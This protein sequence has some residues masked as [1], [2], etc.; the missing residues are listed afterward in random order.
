[1]ISTLGWSAFGILML[2]G[3]DATSGDGLARH[4]GFGP[5]QIYKLHNG[6]SELQ[7]ADLDG[8]GRNDIALWNRWKNRIELFYQ[9]GA[10]ESAS[11]PAEDLERNEIPSRGT[12]RRESIPVPHRVSTLRVGEFTG[13][14]RLDLIYFGEPRELVILP[15]R[16]EGG[17]GPAITT[18]APDGDPRS[19]G[20]AIGDFNGDGRDDAVLRG[21]G[22]VLAYYQQPGGGFSKPERLVHNVKQTMLTLPADLNGDGR[23]DLLMSVDDD[24]YGMMAFV[25]GA[26]GGLGARQRIRISKVRSIT[27]AP[28]RDG[29][30]DV[31]SVESATNRL[32]GLRWGTSPEAGGDW[33]MLLYSYPVVS[34]ANRM[35]SAIADVTG[36]GRLDVVVASVDTAQL[37]LFE[38]RADGL[39]RGRAF[40]GL[41]KTVALAAGDLDGDGRAEVL[42]VSS[43]EKTIGVSRYD[44]E[45]LT[46]PTALSVPG[47]PLGAT[48][49]ALTPDDDAPPMIVC[50]TKVAPEANEDDAG[51]RRRR[52]G[53]QTQV[54]IL[55]AAGGDVLRHWRID[56]L[57][58]DLAGVLLA[59]VNRDGRND[60]LLFVQFAPLV[61]LLQSESGSF[62]PLDGAAARAGLVNDATPAGAAFADVD[63]DGVSEL[64]LAQKNLARV[65]AVRDGHWEVLDQ[66]NPESADAKLTGLA[67]LP[68]GDGSPTVVLYDKQARELIVLRRGDDNTFAVT[69]TMPVGAFDVSTMRAIALRGDEVEL[70]LADP[71]KLAL[72]HPGR[73][74]PAMVEFQTYETDVKDAWLAD[75]VAGDFNHDGVRDVVVMDVRK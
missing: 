65:L 2:A 49:G 54:F 5:T 31:Y 44:G 52:G 30:D 46:F 58:D 67:V 17:F 55:D 34:N 39:A 51:G 72:L 47:E 24:E 20:L 15:G 8:D 59:D 27:I 1:M 28:N 64:L 69:Q 22:Q 23:D 73:K 60:L 25:Q 71:R 3:G 62:E 32:R 38:A 36:D 50:V 63:G 4:F 18:R 7:I 40:P 19:G 6:I 13:D 57:E 61:T 68:A 42:S 56:D 66:L 29:P 48:V 43:E 74:A 70:L 11:D 37:I 33:P 16:E 21:D 53:E 75:S 45:R 14:K 10:G 41:V 9:P 26:G 12:M 35:P